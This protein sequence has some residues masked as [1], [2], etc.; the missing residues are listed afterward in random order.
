MPKKECAKPKGKVKTII[1]TT[2]RKIDTKTGRFVCSSESQKTKLKLDKSRKIKSKRDG[3]SFVAYPE[4]L[5]EMAVRY[6]FRTNA[7]RERVGVQIMGT[8]FSGQTQKDYQSGIRSKDPETRRSANGFKLS[9]IADVKKQL[10]SELKR[11]ILE[12]A[13]KNDAAKSSVVTG[14]LDFDYAALDIG[15]LDSKDRSAL[16]RGVNKFQNASLKIAKQKNGKYKT[17]GRGAMPF[18]DSTVSRFFDAADLQFLAGVKGGA[19][20]ARR[21]TVLERRTTKKKRK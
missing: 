6:K 5:P 13:V 7:K 9:L 8:K 12:F 10:E 17:S 1:V 2:R 11:E 14:V 20:A 15:N 3:S 16:Q 4:G 19:G 21:V 18:N